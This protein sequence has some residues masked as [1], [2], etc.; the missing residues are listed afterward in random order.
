MAWYEGMSRPRSSLPHALPP[1][2]L[3]HHALCG[4]PHCSHCYSLLIAT[5]WVVQVVRASRGTCAHPCTRSLLPAALLHP[6]SRPHCSLSCVP[7]CGLTPSCRITVG[8]YLFPLPCLLATDTS[9][10]SSLFIV[11]VFACMIITY[12]LS[13]VPYHTVSLV[14]PRKQLT[15]RNQQ[16]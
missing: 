7:H 1:P 2:S 6:L 16:R 13:Y 14:T 5:A 4:L 9:G 15:T 3:P 10:C 11:L 12:D 8:S